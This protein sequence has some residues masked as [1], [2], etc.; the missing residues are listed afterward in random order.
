MPAFLF[1]FFFPFCCYSTFDRS[2]SEAWRNSLTQVTV[3]VVAPPGVLSY[4]SRHQ[5]P[6]PALLQLLRRRGPPCTSRATTTPPPPSLTSKHH[7][8]K[9]KLAHLELKR[10]LYKHKSKERSLRVIWRRSRQRSCR[11]LSTLPL[12][13]PLWTAKRSPN[14]FPSY[15]AQHNL[16][17]LSY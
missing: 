16:V 11:I 9:L 6:P 8:L 17:L 2:T 13:E 7:H 15:D 12:S 4:T 3:V 1:F 10:E 5:L 14:S